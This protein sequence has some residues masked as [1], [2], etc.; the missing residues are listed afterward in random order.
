MN[1]VEMQPLWEAGDREGF[2][3]RIV[4]GQK[5]T[6]GKRPRSQLRHVGLT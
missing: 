4:T 6:Q 5:I 3:S 1:D 2:I